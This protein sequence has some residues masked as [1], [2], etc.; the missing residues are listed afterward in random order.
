MKKNGIF[1]KG[2]L[3][4]KTV[5]FCALLVCTLACVSKILERKASTIRFKPFLDHAEDF[6]VLFI[7]DSHTVNG[8][9]PMDL[10]QGYGIAAY[11]MASYGN[12]LPVSYWVM[13]HALEYANPKLMVIGIKDVH[14]HN[15]VSGSSGDLHTAMDCFPLSPLKVRAIE[16]LTNVPYSVDDEGNY[17]ADL[18]WEYYF[19]L[20]KYHSRWSELSEADFHYS[21][22]DQKGGEMAIGVADPRDYD[23]ID[24][25]RA[26]EEEGYGFEYLRKM[27]E[28]CQSRNIDVLLTHLPYPCSENDQMA[29]NA[30]RY[31]AEEYGVAYVDFVN[32]DQVV[33]YEVD[34]YDSFSH[35]NPSGARKV[36]DYFGRLISEHYDIPDRRGEA[37]HR[38]WEADLGAYIDHKLAYLRSQ[39]DLRNLLM[40]LH[41]SCF[42]AC[43]AIR[44]DSP[45]Y[46]DGKAL[47]LLQNIAREHIYEED[48]FAKWSNTL[49]PLASLD[50]AAENRDAYFL[51]LDRA[52]GLLEERV[53][54]DLSAQWDTSFGRV[55]YRAEAGRI[56][57]SIEQDG[58]CTPYAGPDGAPADIRILIVDDRTG[59]VAASLAFPLSKS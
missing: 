19:T 7:G 42:S 29:A 53:G 32:L 57:L 35:L 37:S 38:S 44:E 54:N 59:E 21:L 25:D 48:A 6:D 17:Y 45:V 24:E 47:R 56:G 43:I 26:L 46:D 23:I 27:I 18:K 5:L 49:F 55:D 52:N 11:N 22:N 13:M 41:D 58:V 30:V 20:G 50:A 33:D 39:G 28:E 2:I 3:L 10:W 36:T 51:L 9:F 8:V 4:L 15:K 14:V 16:D 12:T 1:K 40:L 34:C 31:I